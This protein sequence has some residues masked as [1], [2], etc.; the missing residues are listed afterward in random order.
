MKSQLMQHFFLGSILDLLALLLHRIFA[1]SSMVK[2]ASYRFFKIM[3]M[4]SALKH[5]LWKVCLA[6]FKLLCHS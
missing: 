4:D 5:H 3:P 1:S 2:M 6:E